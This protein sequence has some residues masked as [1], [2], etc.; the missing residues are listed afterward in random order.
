MTEPELYGQMWLLAYEA[1]AR[2]WLSNVGGVD[3]VAADPAF[4]F[5]KQHGVRFYRQ[6][7]APTRRSIREL[8]DWRPAYG[9]GD[10]EELEEELVEE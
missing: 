7:R 9:D 10:H 1:N 4:G 2:S 6:V 3:F 5:L 8:P